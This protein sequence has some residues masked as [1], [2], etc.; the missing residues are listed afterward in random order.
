MTSSKLYDVYDTS[1]PGDNR[2]YWNIAHFA[3]EKTV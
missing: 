3:Y 2:R 1:G